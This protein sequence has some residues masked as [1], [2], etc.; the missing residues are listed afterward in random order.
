[1]KNL[2]SKS[3]LVILLVLSGML[4][5]PVSQVLA[6][7]GL[8]FENLTEEVGR[9]F[10]STWNR[11]T[12][13]MGVDE[14]LYVGTW[15]NQTDWPAM[16]AAIASGELADVFNSEENPLAFIGFVA[17][18]GG[19]IWR[20]EGDQSWTR[21]AKAPPEVT[22]FRKMLKYQERL[23]A[24]TANNQ[25][26]A[27][28]WVKEV[29][30]LSTTG[31]TWS[32]LDPPWAPENSSI[33][34]LCTF[35]GSGDDDEKLYVGTENNVSG[36]EL[37]TFDGVNWDHIWT[38]DVHSVAE[39]AVFEDVLYVGTWTFQFD[40]LGGTPSDT[41][42]LFKSEDGVNFQNVKPEFDGREDLSNVGVMTLINFDGRLYL[43]TVNYI[44]GFTL[45]ASRDPSDVDSWEVLTTDG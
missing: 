37:W 34:A 24:G 22:G 2:N 19:E 4:L 18:D 7:K 30:P 12:W 36:G 39:I 21:V 27:E 20:F 25:E 29:D 10:G 8:V 40:F 5:S 35:S 44:D 43:G 6:E 38:F 31:E 26:G 33:R 17:S 28:L 3:A 1:M 23:Y 13:S 15:S 11:Y 42:Q 32:A 9:G 45:L 16:L 14:Y 41:F